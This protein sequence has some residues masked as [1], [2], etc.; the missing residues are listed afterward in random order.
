MMMILNNYHREKVI[1]YAL[2][3]RYKEPLH[4]TCH[5]QTQNKSPM[6]TIKNSLN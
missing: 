1:H 5:L 2:L 3:G 4:K 6:I